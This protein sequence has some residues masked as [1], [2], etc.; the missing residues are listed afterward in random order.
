MNYL[1]FFFWLTGIYSIYYLINILWDL[2]KKHAQTK[3]SDVHHL[4]FIDA[5]TTEKVLPAPESKSQIPFEPITEPVSKGLGGVTMMNLFE[6]ARKE[7][8]NLTTSVS[9]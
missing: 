4:T 2:S 6:L 3:D 7:T 5:N 9:F 8:I 1:H